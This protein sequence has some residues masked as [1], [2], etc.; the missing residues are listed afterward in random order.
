MHIHIYNHPSSVHITVSGRTATTAEGIHDF[1]K[2][3]LEQ[4]V[5]SQQETRT[6][7]L[8]WTTKSDGLRQDGGKV[9]KAQQHLVIAQ[10]GEEDTSISGHTRCAHT[11]VN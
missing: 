9:D 1:V 8:L 4:E 2:Y 10:V 3:L 6:G 5:E 7:V 11:H